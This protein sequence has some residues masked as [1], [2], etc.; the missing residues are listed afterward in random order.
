MYFLVE[1]SSTE[2][3]VYPS[4]INHTIPELHIYKRIEQRKD[5]IQSEDSCYFISGYGYP[6]IINHI[7]KS[8]KD[9]VDFPDLTH[10]IVILDCDEDTVELRTTIIKQEI[11]KHPIFKSVN[12]TILIQNRCIETLF[13]GNKKIITRKPQNKKF[14]EYLAY[15]DVTQN[16]PEM[17]GKKDEHV[18]AHFHEKYLKLA[19]KERGL[20]YSKTAPG[21]V[22]APYY[23][24]EIKQSVYANSHLPTI[25]PFFDLLQDIK[26][27]LSTRALGVAQAAE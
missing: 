20:N 23:L 8:A 13:L 21:E 11:E 25:K 12:T 15:Y 10:F 6:S 2:M 3:D 18:H 9:I 19:F 14:S 17:M 24:N 16:C 7:E 27:D 4:W 22:S 26:N 1:G 5:F